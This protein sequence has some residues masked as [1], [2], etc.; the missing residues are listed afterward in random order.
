MRAQLFRQWLL[1]G[2]A[3]DRDGAK[4]HLS[5][6]LDAEMS[7]AADAL[8]RDQIAGA[9]PG[10]SQR[11][12]DRNPGTQQGSG[13]VRGQIVWN[14]GDS[15]GG[16]KHVF[17]VASIKMEGCNLLVLTIDEIAAAAGFTR[18]AM[19]AMPAHTNALGG[20]PLCYIGAYR[21]DAACNLGAGHTRILDSGPVAFFYQ[22]IAVT[23]A[24]GFDLDA[25]LAPR[26]LRNGAFDDFKISTGLADLNGFHGDDSLSGGTRNMP[27]TTEL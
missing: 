15:F 2:A 18:E 24:A 12:V 14:Q 25:D 19:P 20:L 11:I 23:N 10:I 1:V 5:R 26:R 21:V 4:T 3:S 7:E 13:F 27:G 16:N 9:C 8:H 6:E 22:R 17:L